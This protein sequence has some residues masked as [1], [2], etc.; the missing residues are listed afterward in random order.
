MIS[1][2]HRFSEIKRT[3]KRRVKCSGGCDRT[4]T[5]QRTFS[6]TLNPFNRNAAGEIKSAGEISSELRERAKAWQP[7]ATCQQCL[8]QPQASDKQP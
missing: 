2:T 6:Q 7:T 1:V 5:R 8:K 4:L 3:T